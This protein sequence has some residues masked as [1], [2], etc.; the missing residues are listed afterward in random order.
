M[1]GQKQHL[2]LSIVMQSN[3][4]LYHSSYKKITIKQHHSITTHLS[5]KT[6]NG[7][8]HY[9]MTVSWLLV[10]VKF[11]SWNWTPKAALVESD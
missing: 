11:R 8:Q 4:S 9:Q 2:M 3:N 6:I 10:G 5:S 7:K 1:E